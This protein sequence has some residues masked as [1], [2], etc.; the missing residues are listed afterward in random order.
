VK[1]QTAKHQ[2]QQIRQVRSAK[3]NN[4]GLQRIFPRS[5]TSTILKTHYFTPMTMCFGP[6]PRCISELSKTAFQ[7][8]LNVFWVL[9]NILQPLS[10]CASR[11]YKCVSSPLSNALNAS[12]NVFRG[13]FLPPRGLG[14]L[15]MHNC[16]A[17]FLVRGRPCKYQAGRKRGGKWREV[18]LENSLKVWHEVVSRTVAAVIRLTSLMSRG[19]PWCCIDPAKARSPLVYIGSSPL[20]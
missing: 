16:T 3:F 18:A 10:K 1:I 7:V 5:H 6:L 19:Y 13:R 2:P 17:S 12:P 15:G 8:L 11:P 14:T 20:L 4:L 9:W